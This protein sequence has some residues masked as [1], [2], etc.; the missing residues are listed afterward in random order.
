V[1]AQ[2]SCAAAGDVHAASTGAAADARSLHHQPAPHPAHPTHLL[3][4]TARKAQVLAKSTKMVPVM[5][6]GTLLHQKRYSGLEYLCMSLIGVG[7]GLFARKSSSK[8]GWV[9]RPRLCACACGHPPL[10]RPG[11]GVCQTCALQGG[12]S[13]RLRCR[14][15]CM[16]IGLQSRGND[17]SVEQRAGERR[18]AGARHRQGSQ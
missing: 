13:G 2:H 17:D 3:T 12:A 6:V 1:S 5:L 14:C 15:R 4:R 18:T 9:G 16:E 10:E 7:V 8:V 11:G